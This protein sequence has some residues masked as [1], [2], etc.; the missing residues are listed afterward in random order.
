MIYFC[1]QKNRRALVLQSANLNGIDYL[2]LVGMSVCGKQLAVTLLKDARS[3][4]LTPA[5][6]VITGGT[7]VTI[8]SI[9]P[10]TDEYPFVFIVNLEQTGD[11]SSYTLSLVAAPGITDPPAGFDPQLS[12]VDFSFK[13]GC[14]TPADCLLDT[15]CPAPV[16]APPD[17][18]YLAKDYE[19]F[20]QVMLDRM[21]T[22]SPAWQETHAADLGIALVET[23]AY[24]ADQLSYQQDAV[25]TEAYLNTARSR[26]SLRRH[27]RLVDYIIG[28]GCN[29]RT[30]VCVGAG[31]DNLLIPAGALFYVRVPGLPLAAKLGDPVAQQLAKA[32]QPVFASLQDT[33]LFQEQNEIH[34]YAWG[35]TRCC[36]VPNA[37][38]ATLAGNLTTLKTGDVLVFLEKC[39]PLTG[40]PQD[41]DPT[42]RWAVCL[43]SVSTTDHLGN[44]LVDPLNAQL[45]TRITWSQDDALP[46][47]LCISSVTDAE[48]GLI[49]VPAVSVA[50]GNVIAADHG[51]W[52]DSEQLDIVPPAPAAPPAGAGCQCGTQAEASAPRPHYYPELANSP[53]TFAVP[54][55]GVQTASAFLA[56]DPADALPQVGLQSDDGSSWTAE[57]DLL[58]SDDTDHVFVPEIERD[59]SIFLRFGDGQYGKFPDAGLSFLATYRVGNGNIGNIAR[60]SLA[61][62][63]LPPTFL[64][65]LAEILSVGNPLA[66]SGG[67]DPE[68]MDHIR[69]YA[70][71]AYQTQLRCVTENDYGVAAAGFPGIREARGTLRWTGSWYT[72][73]VSVDPAA[74]FTAALA[75]DTTRRLNLLRMMGTDLAAEGA[76]LVGLDIEMEICVAAN[77][78]QGD[79]FAA[80]MKL[81]ITGNQCSGQAGLLNPANFAFGQTVYAS[82]LIAAAQAVEGVLSATLTV[83]KRM[84]NPSLDGAAQGFLTMG[85]LEIAR[86]DNDPNRLD[87]GIFVL[88]MDG[89]K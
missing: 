56:S 27:A 73:F 75:S 78:F 49:P 9:T 53:L 12:S 59:N 65:P 19:G 82:P 80:L 14:P 44:V 25:S 85:R 32:N 21:A 54:F 68:V 77:H 84:D 7:A 72:A 70:P 20:R 5:N 57:K 42:H 87:H 11:F 55:T 35:D 83:F 15:C 47:P 10:A 36:L 23:L 33:T 71:F 81:F 8:S 22:L 45:I 34:F 41:A 51:V 40:D 17:I 31:K 64:P 86:C 60:D 50:L 3:I 16:S 43:T 30:F 63:V 79:V 58:S 48:H 26:I 76:V 28:E 67:L 1:S 37:T 89:G 69:Q 39:G 66:A 13:V 74:T 2:E 88:H 52:I 46:F 38:E 4:A 24:A 18:N 6:I 29:A 61:H 62:I